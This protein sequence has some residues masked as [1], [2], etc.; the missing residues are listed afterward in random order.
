[1]FYRKIRKKTNELLA[2]IKKYSYICD[3]N[4]ESAPPDQLAVSEEP[5]AGKG[6]YD[7]TEKICERTWLNHHLLFLWTVLETDFS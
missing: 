2:R 1:M 4:S 5:S 6:Q 7:I 3:I